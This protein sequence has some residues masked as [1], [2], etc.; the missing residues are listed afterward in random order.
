MP[1]WLQYQL[2]EPK[3]I[4]K[5]AFRPRFSFVRTNPTHP[6]EKEK[7]IVQSDCPKNYTFE[8]SNDNT[9]FDVLLSL[10]NQPLCTFEKL[11]VH[12]FE[13]DISYKF[14]R[15]NVT[16]VPGRWKT[17]EKF[18]VIGDVRVYG[19]EIC[20]STETNSDQSK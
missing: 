3:R 12:S 10:T 2:K 19:E 16:D 15:L 4:C 13:N 1:Q 20:N 8:G 5:F 17:E 9:T 14:Y 18:V 7:T 6:T 11:V